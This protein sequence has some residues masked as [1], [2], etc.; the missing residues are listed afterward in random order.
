MPYK[1]KEDAIKNRK[2]YFSENREEILKKQ[3]EY[4]LSNKEKRNQKNRIYHLNNK[5]KMNKKSSDY[6]S[7]NKEKIHEIKHT[8]KWYINLYSTIKR[9]NKHI[10][11]TDC[12]F[13]SNY[14]KELFETNQGICYWFK[15][16][17]QPSI[18]PRYPLQPSIDRLDNTKG[19]VKDN[20]VICCLFANT[21]RSN[22]YVLEWENVI[23]IIKENI[24]KQD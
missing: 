23:K 20:I 22:T 24:K 16:P 4:H 12:D 17:M 14:L 7:K 2:K 21:G 6:Y 5:E 13:N 3:R 9:R 10:F 15:I 18:N 11:K 1:N 8:D 19:Y